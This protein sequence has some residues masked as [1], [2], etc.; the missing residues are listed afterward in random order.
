MS[1]N[2]LKQKENKLILV[3]LDANWEMTEK[4]IKKC[5][6]SNALINWAFT[7]WFFVTKFIHYDFDLLIDRKGWFLTYTIDDLCDIFELSLLKVITLINYQH[8]K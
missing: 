3:T 1:K 5:L 4:S 8:W 2:S 6:V 7:L